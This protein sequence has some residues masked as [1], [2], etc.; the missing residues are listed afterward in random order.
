VTSARAATP[1]PPLVAAVVVSYH[2]DLVQI[3]RLVR[4]VAPQVA[5]L[6]VVDN[7]SPAGTVAALREL[8]TADHVHLEALATNVGIAAAQNRGIEIARGLGATH[9]LLSDDDSDPGT[10]MVARLLAAITG[11]PEQDRVAAVGP[12]TVDPRTGSAPLVFTD[13]HAGPRR[14]AAL[15]TEPGAQVDVAF[16]IASGCL[17]DL[18]ALDDV[19]PMNEALFI[20]HVDLE[21]GVRARRAGWRLRVVVDAQLTHSLGDRTARVLWRSRDVHIQSPVRNYY[22]VRNTLWLVR[23]GLLPTRWRRGYLRWI[24]RYVAYYLVAVAPRATRARLMARAVRDVIAHRMGPL[25][26]PARPAA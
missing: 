25:D 17:I 18:R 19:G 2:P 23:S 1:A 3:S 14:I 16:L 5:E 11:A 24:S 6:I 7:G 21:W 13:Q 15:P 12:V 4:N 20:D 10:D 22:M 9:V 8:A 26:G